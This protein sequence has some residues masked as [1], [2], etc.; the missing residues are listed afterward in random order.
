LED[1][2]QITQDFSSIM[3]EM[4]QRFGTDIGIISEISGQDYVV[5]QTVSEMNV[6]KPG[7]RFVT[8]DTY[9][10]EV[11]GQ[12]ETVAY[13]E[14]GKIKSM[15][16]HPVYTAMQLEAYIGTPIKVNGNILGTLNF[17]GFS[18]KEPSF[19]QED[20]LLVEDLARQI[21]QAIVV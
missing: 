18:P 9:C 6:L 8:K 7:D 17:S 21:E 12:A 16:L 5:L 11:V 4:N 15:V 19:N 20:R 10:N 13:D 3:I 14:V 2:V 1:D